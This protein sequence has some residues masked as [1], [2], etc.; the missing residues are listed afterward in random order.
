MRINMW[1]QEYME[2]GMSYRHG[3]H[4]NRMDTEIKENRNATA[5][6]PRPWKKTSFIRSFWEAHQLICLR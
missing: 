5:V 6:L 2:M 4:M 3:M 1:K